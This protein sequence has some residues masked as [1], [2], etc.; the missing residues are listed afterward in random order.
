MGLGAVMTTGWRYSNIFLL[1]A[2]M[3][4]FVVA[5]RGD[6]EGAKFLENIRCEEVIEEFSAPR[7]LDFGLL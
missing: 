5:T 6:V 7:N 2:Y 3:Y 1:Q 4:L